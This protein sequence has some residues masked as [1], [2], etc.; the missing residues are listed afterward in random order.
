MISL[1]LNP[2]TD[3]EK[4]ALDEA[5]AAALRVLN[6]KYCGNFVTTTCAECQYRHICY[7]IEKAHSYIHSIVNGGR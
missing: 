7:D 3:A 2:Y 4:K 1:R 6:E 5:F